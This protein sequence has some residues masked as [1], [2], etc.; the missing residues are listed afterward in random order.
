MLG[1][2]R[3]LEDGESW[4]TSINPSDG[5]VIGRVRATGR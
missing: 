3:W 4:L 1:P 2:A 5:K